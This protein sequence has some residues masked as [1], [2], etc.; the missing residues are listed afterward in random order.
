MKH[1]GAAET[2]VQEKES[3]TICDDSAKK[4]IRLRGLCKDEDI[5]D[6]QIERDLKELNRQ[7]EEHLL[8][9]WSEA[10]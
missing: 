2:L 6:E 4:L 3:Y 10:R 9:E 8:S 1:D 5:D 7:S